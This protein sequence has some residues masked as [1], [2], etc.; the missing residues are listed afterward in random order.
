MDPVLQVR[1]H[2]HGVEGQDHPL[3]PA[4]HISFDA[5]QDMVDFLGC[6]G[7]L[8]AHVQLPIQQYIPRSFWQDGAQSFHLPACTD[9]GGC[10][11]PGSRPCTW[12]C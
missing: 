1:S 8:L 10:H 4:G 9:S 2:Q 3:C 12:I 5:A 11:N 7:T 6:E